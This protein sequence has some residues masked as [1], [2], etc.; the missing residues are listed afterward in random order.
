MKWVMWHSSWCQVILRDESLISDF[1]L[2]R[3]FAEAN[4]RGYW[5]YLYAKRQQNFRKYLL[6]DRRKTIHI[7]KFLSVHLSVT[8]VL[9]TQATILG[10]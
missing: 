3:E 8:V 7:K 2:L 9:R 4:L 6:K 1:S 10:K 5:G